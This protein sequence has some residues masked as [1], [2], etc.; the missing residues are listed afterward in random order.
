MGTE[1]WGCSRVCLRVCSTL[2]SPPRKAPS[3][4]GVEPLGLN[5][6][7]YPPLCQP[8]PILHWGAAT[9]PGEWCPGALPCSASGEG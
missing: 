3:S 9:A 5:P 8:G 4:E 1:G 6:A 7:P 2:R